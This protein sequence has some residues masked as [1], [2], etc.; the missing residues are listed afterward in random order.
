MKGAAQNTVFALG[1]C[2]QWNLCCRVQQVA[3]MPATSVKCHSSWHQLLCSWYTL[4]KSWQTVIPPSCIAD[5]WPTQSQCYAN[6]QQPTRGFLSVH[7][8]D[9]ISL[10]G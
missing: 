5:S 3:G 10:G 6:T 8:C 1:V 4:N 2:W 7:A 9:A